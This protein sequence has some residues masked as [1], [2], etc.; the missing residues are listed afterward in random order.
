MLLAVCSMTHIT[1]NHGVR[2]PS[3]RHTAC[4]Y[5]AQPKKCPANAGHSI[6]LAGGL[7]AD[8]LFDDPA[9]H[10]V[11]IDAAVGAETKFGA[12]SILA[13]MCEGWVVKLTLRLPWIIEHSFR[14]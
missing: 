11:D 3:L 2:E 9:T 7:P 10:H 5:A 13:R 6:P 4:E 12:H 14:S 1:G 8:R